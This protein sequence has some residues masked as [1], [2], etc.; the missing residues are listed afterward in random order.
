MPSVFGSGFTDKNALSIITLGLKALRGGQATRLKKN[1]GPKPTHP[2]QPQILNPQDSR[3]QSEGTGTDDSATQCAGPQVAGS[4][5]K[6]FRRCPFE[7]TCPA[8]IPYPEHQEGHRPPDTENRSCA[9]PLGT[10][11]HD[12][13][14]GFASFVQIFATW[15][16]CSSESYSAASLGR[17]LTGRSPDSQLTGSLRVCEKACPKSYASLRRFNPSHSTLH[18]GDMLGTPAPHHPVHPLSECS[19]RDE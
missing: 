10:W 1:Q 13:G 17:P 16:A 11:C 9:N 3:Y 18:D 6:A 2:T 8:P 19:K 7:R 14:C 12:T 5:A 15:T 4:I